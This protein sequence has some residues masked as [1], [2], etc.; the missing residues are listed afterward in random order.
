MKW[1]V[2]VTNIDKTLTEGSWVVTYNMLDETYPHSIGQ[3]LMVFAKDEIGVFYAFNK[4]VKEWSWAEW[5]TDIEI[6]WFEKEEVQ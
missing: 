1:T 3:T 2:Q 6:T 5:V 4:A